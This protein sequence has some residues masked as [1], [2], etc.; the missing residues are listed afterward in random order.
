MMKLQVKTFGWL[1]VW[2]C[3]IVLVFLLW[4][5]RYEEGTR[6]QK[7][8]L[9][10]NR[11]VAVN[12]AVIATGPI[13]RWIVGEG[14]VEAVSK[15]I[16]QFE[17]PGNV[18]FVARDSD[19]GYLREGSNISGPD[20]SNQ[21]GQ[22]LAMIDNRDTQAEIRQSKAALAEARTNMLAQIS[23]LSQ[24]K[25]DL[26]EAFTD[27]KRNRLLFSKHVL[28]KSSLDKCETAY[29]NATDAVKRAEADVAAASSR[30]NSAEA[31]LAKARRGQDRVALYA[32]FNGLVA[33]MNIKEGDYFDLDDVDH[34]SET[35]LL[36]TAAIIVIDPSEME[37][38][39]YLP[40]F[41]GREVKPGQRV[42]VV[43]GA[44]D[45]L[46]AEKNKKHSVIEGTVHAVSPQV[47]A[48]RRAIRIKIRFKQRENL[49]MDGMFV[50]CWIAAD[51]REN[52]LR[53]PLA[54]L[55]FENDQPYAFGIGN[56]KAVRRWLELGIIDDAYAEV[57]KGLK[58]D[59]FVACKGRKQLH[60]GQSVRVVGKS[61]VPCAF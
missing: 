9:K 49:I 60:S 21:K 37:V 17:E 40:E 15:R 45:G 36:E 1:L 56:G 50:T 41:E 51:T 14:G 10:E 11:P 31:V 43:P 59:E 19:G 38:T 8:V 13:T 32:P 28:A 25:N 53:I 12:G 22:L 3:C 7:Q 44:V 58:K 52:V 57:L 48:T 2:A 33:R 23:V 29:N 46:H 20:G 47:D 55:L 24:A 61:E 26:K 54:C 16:L 34:S 27:V 4:L 35:Q 30:V 39:L 18:V 5:E 6:R 42:V